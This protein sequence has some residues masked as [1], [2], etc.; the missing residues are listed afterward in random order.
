LA[1]ERILREFL[2]GLLHGLAIAPE[3]LH[4]RQ[5][6][7]SGEEIWMKRSAI[8]AGFSARVIFRR[9]VSDPGAQ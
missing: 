8:L 4:V 7:V 5:A 2:H 3:R 9:L 1:P 6:G